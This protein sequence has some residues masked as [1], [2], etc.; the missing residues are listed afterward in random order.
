M[1]LDGYH[2]DGSRDEE[3]SA[4][5]DFWTASIIWLNM[6]SI[7]M[8][9]GARPA[10]G[11]EPEPLEVSMLG[12]DISVVARWWT[13]EGE[14]SR[15]DFE[16]GQRFSSNRNRDTLLDATISR[17]TFS[18][19]TSTRQQREDAI[20]T[21]EKKLCKINRLIQIVFQCNYGLSPSRP[22]LNAIA[23]E[24]VVPPVPNPRRL[25]FQYR[26]RS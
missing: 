15:A 25:S 3:R 17:C 10:V 9:T 21:S 14:L 8:G 11:I 1:H 16:G 18:I 13:R 7:P 19:A 20:R 23:H 24:V 22:A 4:L 26:A 2:N 6:A 5:T 12:R